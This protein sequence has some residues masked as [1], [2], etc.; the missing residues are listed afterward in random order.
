M[1]IIFFREILLFNLYR[2]TEGSGSY[3]LWTQL[4]QENLHT[5]TSPG[6]KHHVNRSSGGAEADWTPRTTKS[7]SK[8]TLSLGD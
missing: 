2:F 8:R 1:D 6:E 7:R 5:Q 3:S 4:L